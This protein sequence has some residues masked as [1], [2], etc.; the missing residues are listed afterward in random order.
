L[1]AHL[2]AIGLPHGVPRWELADRQG[3]VKSPWYAW[4]VLRFEQ[5]SPFVD[6]QVDSFEANALGPPYAPDRLPPLR[7][8][9]FVA[10]S[11]EA[12][13]N[14]AHALAVIEARY[15]PG[16]ER[17]SSNTLGH[18]WP[19]ENARIRVTTWP[20]ELERF[21]I[22]N[23]AHARHPELRAFTHLTIETGHVPPLDASEEEA[24]RARAP[25]AP[26]P[27]GA[28]AV[29]APF[30]HEM[31]RGTTRWLPEALASAQPEVG[32]AGARIVGAHDRVAF[33]VER[34]DVVGLELVRASPARGPGGASLALIFEDVGSTKRER[35]SRMLF[36]GE[37][38]HLLDE[39]AR[40]VADTL[41]VALDVKDGMDD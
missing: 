41:E 27:R 17:G 11:T 4:D 28:R 40:R 33:V 21:P 31:L 1:L 38:T 26:L 15:G 9:T 23:P 37:A 16:L 30:E 20:P 14:H 36:D 19:L 39:V 8:S 24:I 25:L 3:I 5:A 13:V 34:S 7:F 22:T 12:R 10:P 35:R 32:I 29:V 6:G 18:E 2:D